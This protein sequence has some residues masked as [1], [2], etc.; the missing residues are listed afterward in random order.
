MNTYIKV[1]QN[2]YIVSQIS[3]LVEQ[4]EMILLDFEIPDPPVKS[5]EYR[6]NIN[7][8]TWDKV[9]YRSLEDHKTEK[10]T[11]IKNT[12]NSL[13][14]G[15]FTWNNYE[16]DSDT[17]SQTRIQGAVQLAQLAISNSSPFSIDWT[18]KN[19]SI[20]VLS[21]E[22]MIQVGLS[23]ANHVTSIHEISRGLKQQIDS[24]INV[25]QLA[26]INWPE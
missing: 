20:V 4:P 5:P 1:D 6:Y 26:N 18:L 15:G 22:E 13:E 23:L 8:K 14:F 7:T 24:A 12:R 2:G 3:S 19:N 21:A 17:I 10:W 16:F 9:D 25:E 11:D